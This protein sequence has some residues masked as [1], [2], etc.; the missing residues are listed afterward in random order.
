M[1]LV[2]MSS[3][4]VGKWKGP[5]RGTR[6]GPRASREASALYRKLWSL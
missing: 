4:V 2:Q 6:R 5:Q 3:Y 1:V